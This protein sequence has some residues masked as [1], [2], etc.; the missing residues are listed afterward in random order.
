MDAAQGHHGRE[1]QWPVPEKFLSLDSTGY[2]YHD[3]TVLLVPLTIAADAPLGQVD[4]SGK[5]GWLE[6]AKQCVPRD[7]D[8]SIKFALGQAAKESA[9]ANVLKQWQKLP[10]PSEAKSSA[11]AWWG[12][13]AV[14]D[15]RKLV[16]EFD[17]GE[18]KDDA[19]FFSLPYEPF[20]LSA[21]SKVSVTAEGRM[22][23]EKTVMKFEGD[24]PG[25]VAGLLV[26]HLKDRDKTSAVEVKLPIAA[27]ANSPAPTAGTTNEPAATGGST[28]ETPQQSF[29]LMLF[30]AFLG[31]LI[32]NIMPCVLPVISLKILGFVKQ[33]QESP[34][35]VRLLGLLYGAGVLVSFLILAG[36]VIGVKSAGGLAGW[37]MQMSNPQFVVLLTILVTLVALNLF[38]LFEVTLG[39]VGV[40]A[41]SVASKEG[42]G[43]A[44]FN[45][46]LATILATPCTAPFLAPAL[47]FAFSQSSGVIVLMFIAVAVGLALPYVVL[48]WNP[49]WLR[50]LPAGAVDGKIQD[51]HGLPDARDGDVAVHADLRILRRTDFVVWYFSDSAGDGALGVRRIFSTGH[52]AQ[53]TSACDGRVDDAG[54]RGVRSGGPVAVAQP[55]RSEFKVSR[56]GAGF[57]RWN[58]VAHLVAGGGRRCTEK[59]PTR[60]GGFHGQVVCDLY[61][62]Q[63]T[64]IDIDSVRAVMVDK[65]IKAFRADYTRRPDHITRELAKW[66]RAGVPLVL[67]YSPDTTVRTQM[68]PEVLTPGIVLDALG[69]AG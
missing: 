65:N 5:V 57:S 11:K 13:E 1:I 40:A 42:A 23:V 33:S 69:K 61:R 44:F 10:K 50:F 3:E 45:G 26:L 68:L 62:Q 4:I 22:R 58:Q 9:S 6:C 36:V 54:G 8:V 41:G 67:V 55:D 29:G 52:S 56:R 35:R 39:S 18:A 64:S 14:E 7:Q 17:P 49:K 53:G 51:R 20:E 38:G 59:W 12:G 27:D 21:E 66:N 63:K 46:V 30:Y 16:I 15:E 37:G 24:W 48:S 60:A 47:G 28:T 32:L 19:D 2:G 34:A 25:E 31:G 43:G